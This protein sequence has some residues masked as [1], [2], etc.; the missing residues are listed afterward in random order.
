MKVLILTNY[1][2]KAVQIHTL[3]HQYTEI[4]PFMCFLNVNFTSLTLENG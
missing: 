4:S 3:S 1:L 2:E